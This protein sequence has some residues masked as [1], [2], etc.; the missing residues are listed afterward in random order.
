MRHTGAIA[1]SKARLT[2]AE[3]TPAQKAC[4]LAARANGEDCEACQ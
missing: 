3:M 2:E 4:S 1:A